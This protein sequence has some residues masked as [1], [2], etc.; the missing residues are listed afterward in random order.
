VEDILKIY[1]FPELDFNDPSTKGSSSAFSQDEEEVI[2][3][4][5]QFCVG[6]RIQPLIEF[7]LSSRRSSLKEA[8]DQEMKEESDSKQAVDIYN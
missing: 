2:S 3:K 5:I 7:L 1:N 4:E 6:S 8:E